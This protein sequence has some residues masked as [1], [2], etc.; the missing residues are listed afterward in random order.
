MDATEHM[1]RH[2]FAVKASKGHAGLLVAPDFFS[3]IL[4]DPTTDEVSYASTHALEDLIEKNGD[5]GALGFALLVQL[6]RLV[7]QGSEQQKLAKDMIERQGSLDLDGVLDR[8]KKIVGEG[9][10]LANLEAQLQERLGD[11]AA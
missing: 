1:K 4:R 8:V 2:Q 7:Q 10:P 9:G 11:E 6:Q 3:F 5:L